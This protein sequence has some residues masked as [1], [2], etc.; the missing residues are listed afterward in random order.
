MISDNLHITLALFCS[1]NDSVALGV[2][3]FHLGVAYLFSIKEE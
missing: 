1:G 2:L 3:D